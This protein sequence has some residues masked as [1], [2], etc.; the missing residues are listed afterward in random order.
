MK[1]RLKGNSLRLRL[2]KSEIARLHGGGLLEESTVFGPLPSQRLIYTLS[3]VS[4]EQ[5]VSASFDGGRIDVRISSD[6]VLR[7]AGSEE[8]AVS[9]SQT[10]GNEALLRIL[11]EKDLECLDPA[12]RE[13]QEDAFPHPQSGALCGG[14]GAPS[15]PEESGT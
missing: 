2:G 8:L 4:A 6:V 15:S 9:A 3:T 12:A 13:S 5:E 10:I 14:R 1:L 11:I 7:W